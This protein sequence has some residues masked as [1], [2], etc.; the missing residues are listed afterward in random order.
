MTLDIV[1][2]SLTFA[3]PFQTEFPTWVGRLP[4]MVGEPAAGSLSADE[5]KTL[6]LIFGPLAVSTKVSLQR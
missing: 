5:W 2:V 6:V 4:S 1:P 3:Y